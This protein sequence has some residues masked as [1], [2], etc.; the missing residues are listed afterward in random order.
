M[1]FLSDLV[2]MCFYK[3][4]SHKPSASSLCL[5]NVYIPS[6]AFD[7]GNFSFIGL[8]YFYLNFKFVI[9]VEYP[10]NRVMPDVNYCTVI[11][12]FNLL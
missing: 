3:N 9:R 1:D 7:P 11:V 5:Y 4:F 12:V 2:K 8:F 6:V 10:R